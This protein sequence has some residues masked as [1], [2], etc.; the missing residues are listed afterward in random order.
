MLNTFPLIENI[1]FIN[2][3]RVF[4]IFNDYKY[5]FFL[6]SGMSKYGLGQYSF[7]GFDPFLVFKS[8]GENVEIFAGDFRRGDPYDQPIQFHGDP[9]AILRQIIDQYKLP[10]LPDLPSFL[11]GGVGY[12]S[13]EMKNLI[14]K[15]P[16]KAMDDIDIPDCIVCLYDVILI[17]DHK[18]KQ[19]YISSSG[20][21]EQDNNLR[22]KRAIYRIKWVKDRLKETGEVKS[23]KLKVKSEEL[24]ERGQEHKPTES[25]T[26]NLTHEEYIQAVIKAKEYIAQ[27][28]IYQVNL[29]QRLMTNLVVPPFRLYQ[30]LRRINP[31]PF[32][33]YLDFGEVVIAGSS[34]ERFL[35]VEGKIVETRPIK[36]TR[37]RGENRAEDKRLRQELLLSE[38]DR[39]E[40]MMIVDL[41]R[42]DLGRVCKY[43]SI[44]VKNIRR[45]E[46][47]PT[48]FHTVA[49]IC[50]ELSTRHDRFD[51]LKACF[52][53]GSI[54]GA[55]KIRAIEIINELEPN[56]R[57]IYTGCIGY[58]SF[59]GSMDMNIAIRTFL[60]K[61]N[62]VYFHVGGGIVADSSPEDE[63]METFHKGKAL[64][65]AVEIA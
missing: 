47:H 54:T 49:T 53:G 9:F 1:P 11:G 8:K 15:L 37:P 46:S 45:L 43:G 18:Q 27:G 21:P 62:Q 14:E 38:K 24:G 44:V 5:P 30:Q 4:P 6:D 32:G 48:V 65:K 36:G 12:F 25:I 35:S 41:L 3:V 22:Q 16:V 2:P 51:L 42:N 64:I 26:S 59:T 7:I 63:Y 31:A 50:G 60:I 34:P 61:G 28:D 57:H 33:S 56:K 39:A 52:P 10:I 13:Y 40:L 58:L 17:F 20:F 23:E 19:A 29:S 55:P